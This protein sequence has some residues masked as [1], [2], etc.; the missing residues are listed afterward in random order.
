MMW[1]ALFPVIFLLYFFLKTFSRKI[2]SKA[3]KCR[4]RFDFTINFLMHDNRVCRENRRFSGVF[5]PSAVKESDFANERDKTLLSFIKIWPKNLRNYS[6]R[7]VL[8][9]KQS[10]SGV[11]SGTLGEWKWMIVGKI[12]GVRSGI[13]SSFNDYIR[14]ALAPLAQICYKRTLN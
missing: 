10:D 9:V 2:K 5:S 13:F 6:F 14:A 3:E 1:N 7:P 8:K 12:S 4:F 11:A